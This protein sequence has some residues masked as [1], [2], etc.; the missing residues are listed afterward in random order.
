LW[1][2]WMECLQTSRLAREGT[3]AST[4]LGLGTGHFLHNDPTLSTVLGT[5]STTWARNRGEWSDRPSHTPWPFRVSGPLGV[6]VDASMDEL[7]RELVLAAMAGARTRASARV[8]RSVSARTARPRTASCKAALA[9][10]LPN[11][12]QSSGCS[13]RPVTSGLPISS[14]RAWR[15]HRAASSAL[16]RPNGDLSRSR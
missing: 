3:R 15:E 13:P 2:R 8:P 10:F 4:I 6:A 11:S 12:P 14:R 7:T 5:F 9:L 16:D 1:L